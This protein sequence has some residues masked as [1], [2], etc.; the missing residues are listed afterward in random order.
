M[1]EEI[2]ATNAVT[3]YTV[4]SIF[5]LSSVSQMSL[6]FIER[7][8]TT[9]ICSTN[10]LEMDFVLISR[11]LASSHLNIDSELQIYS[12][13]EAWLSHNVNER[14]K[15][16]TNVLL[17][18]RFNLLSDHALKFL[19]SKNSSFHNNVEVVAK[20]KD[21]LQNR[22]LGDGNKSKVVCKSRYCDQENDFNIIVCG[23][24]DYAS[25]KRLKKALITNTGSLNRFKILPEL[26]NNQQCSSIVCIKGEVYVFGGDDANYDRVWPI[27]KY[28]PG[29]GAWENAGDF[30]DDRTGFGACSLMG[31]I[32]IVGG[33]D[34]NFSQLASCVEFDTKNRKW[35]E[36]ARMNQARYKVS[37]TVYNGR[38]VAS[39]G[40]GVGDELLKSVEAYDHIADEWSYL[41]N[42]IEA[43]WCHKS[44]AVKNKLFILGGETNL[45]N[46]EKNCEVFDSFSRKFVLLKPLPPY[47]LDDYSE[48]CNIE[49]I[50]IGK[51]LVVFGNLK[52]VVRI[53]DLENDCWSEES[54]EMTKNLLGFCC[55]KVP[56]TSLKT[57]ID[58]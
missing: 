37:C 16:S 4:A 39:G 14:G 32:Y 43:R 47:S 10:F 55:V 34:R 29:T 49:V 54:C 2:N 5:S 46:F 35:R 41:P 8:F 22:K 3:L 23:G 18:T 28:S 17:K 30:Y 11:V 6:W 58:Y 53:Y 52:N 1:K 38:I 31:N 12:A 44:V 57:C 21:V 48:Y 19:L 56:K 26:K 20:M 40:Y 42:M 27:E 24:L 36:V 7:C 15:Y 51:K 33:R 50:P 13:A 25:G 9:V 45:A